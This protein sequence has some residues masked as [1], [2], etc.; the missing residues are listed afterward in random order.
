MKVCKVFLTV[1][2]LMLLLCVVLALA[3]PAAAA[4]NLAVNGDLEMGSTNGWEIA[5]ADLDSSVKYAG[6]YS[7]K[8]NATTAYSGAAYKIVPVNRGGTVTVSFYYRYVSDPGSNLYHVFTYKGSDHT[9]GTY[10][11]ADASFAKPSGCNSISTWKYI[12]YSFNAEEYDSIYL[13]FSPGGNGSSPCY[14]DNLEVK[15]EGGTE[16]TVAP[17]L[18]SF[19]TKYNRPR[20]AENNLITNGGFES[21]THAPWDTDTFI[22]GNLSVVSDATAPEGS[23]SLYLTSGTLSTTA[24]Y[25]FPVTV[26]KNTSY[27]FSA[28][29]KSPRLSAQNNATATFGVADA[30]T[31][32]FLIYEPYNGDGHGTA[33]KSTATMQ[34]MA[35]SPDGEWHLRSVTF[36]SGTA[37][38]VNIAVYGG[39]SQLY[40][41]D[42][43]LYKSANG[44]EYISERRTATITATNNKGNR[45]CLDENSL[46]PAPHMSGAAAQNYW[47]D[48]PAWR[49]GFL[50]FADTGDSHGTALKYTASAN[51]MRSLWYIDWI[52]LQPH[53]EYTLTMDIKRLATGGGKIVLLDDNVNSPVEFYSVSLAAV[54]SDW[55]TYSIT[56]N[57]GVYS[58]IGFAIVDAGG[59]AYIDKLRLFKTA[60]G[61]AD[62]PA[63]TDTPV[64]KPTG[65]LTAVTEF[66]GAPVVQLLAD[67]DFEGGTVGSFAL[68][69][70]SAVSAAAAHSGAYGVHLGGDGT[71]GAMLEQTAIPVTDGKTYILSY[72]YK[73]NANGANITIKGADTGTQY[74]YTW[75]NQGAWTQVTATFTVAGDTAVIF[76]V[77]GSNTG[78]AEDLYLDDISLTRQGPGAPVGVAF[79]M[80]LD[81]AG[82]RR[83]QQYL[84]D[85]TNATV[86]VYGDGTQ[87]R[88]VRM[89]AVMTNDPAVGDSTAAFVVEAADGHRVVDVPATYLY[90]AAANQ[91]SY[92]VRVVNIPAKFADTLIYARP[93]YVFEKD[94][95]EITVYGAVYS[96]SYNDPNGTSPFTP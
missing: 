5:N 75:A 44:I 64:V 66:A 14:I 18:T 68:Y 1:F 16:S 37:T 60:D 24:W 94:G 72:W 77:C 74:V 84:G 33:T 93:Y 85:L 29:V 70:R 89:G 59:S 96:R 82:A 49:N 31:G 65:G 71:W 95:E 30:D 26:E 58:R 79:L 57:T 54:D 35:T 25:T 63:N 69:Q 2:S 11:K 51:T 9:V 36:Y 91:V 40:L 61:I 88:L 42:I 76:N 47:S 15:C 86:D 21:V 90:E 38:T 83:D 27:T 20:S 52:D 67:G 6:N 39:G 3:L 7:L 48:N 34:L 4:D 55:R 87:Y 45:Y 81:A 80:Q 78:M 46:I 43:A 62:E 56:F 23:K 28:W 12:S 41:D 22:K 17:Y 13:K 53:T 19:G 92:A 32:D 8:L 73:A 10:D 50:S